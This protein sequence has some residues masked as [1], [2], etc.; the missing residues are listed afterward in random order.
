MVY[1]RDSRCKD[2]RGGYI[3]SQAFLGST[4]ITTSQNQLDFAESAKAYNGREKCLRE[5]GAFAGDGTG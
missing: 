5:K 3:D 2:L 1:H 4:I